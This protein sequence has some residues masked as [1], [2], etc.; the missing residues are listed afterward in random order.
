[1]SCS[2]YFLL[3]FII[4]GVHLG[5]IFIFVWA[6]L[7]PKSILIG[8]T[9]SEERSV[10]LRVSFHYDYIYPFNASS[11]I[12]S[13]CRIISSSLFISV[14]VTFFFPRVDISNTSL[15][16]S[17]PAR[18]WS[19]VACFLFAYKSEF[20][21]IINRALLIYIFIEN[22]PHWVQ[23]TAQIQSKFHKDGYMRQYFWHFL[24]KYNIFLVL[25]PNTFNFDQCYNYLAFRHTV[26]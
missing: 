15:K 24:I 13:M 26:S 10:V 11:N 17:T 5:C 12:V 22:R 21:W 4:T 20:P 23:V 2:R 25:K 19:C 14:S 16:D 1:M 9:S 18:F 6:T 7:I 3:T 8:D